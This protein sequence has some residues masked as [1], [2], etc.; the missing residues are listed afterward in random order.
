MGWRSEA[1]EARLQLA[2]EKQRLRGEEEKTEED[3]RGGGKYD[4]MQKRLEKNVLK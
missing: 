1:S 3:R 2:V 4:N